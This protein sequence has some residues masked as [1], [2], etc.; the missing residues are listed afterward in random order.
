MLCVSMFSTSASSLGLNFVS[1][2]LFRA[3][4]CR[5]LDCSSNNWKLPWCSHAYPLWLSHLTQC[6]LVLSLLSKCFSTVSLS[7]SIILTMARCI[8]FG[9]LPSH[10]IIALLFGINMAYNISTKPLGVDLNWCYHVV[11]D[12]DIDA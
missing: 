6:T 11:V 3:I 12:F 10:G 2:P 1:R 4:Y 8:N 5:F 9:S 7:P